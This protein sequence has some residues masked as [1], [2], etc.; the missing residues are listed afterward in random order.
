VIS[1]VIKQVERGISEYF[2]MKLKVLN[3]IIY[4][5]FIHL[6]DKNLFIFPIMRFRADL[7]RS[8]PLDCSSRSSL[9]LD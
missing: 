2:S 5:A 7:F 3:I 9:L 8:S 6:E 1:Y 4:E